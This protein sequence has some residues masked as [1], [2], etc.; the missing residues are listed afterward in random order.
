MH[1]YVMIKYNTQEFFRISSAINCL[2]FA[3]A[4]VFNKP[5]FDCALFHDWIE[6]DITE[7]FPQEIMLNGDLKKF[8][9][10]ELDIPLC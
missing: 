1:Q 2:I 7:F 4:K 5:S 10:V 6:L 8:S 3:E 9:L